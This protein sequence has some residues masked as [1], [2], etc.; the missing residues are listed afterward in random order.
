MDR[1][2]D[3]LVLIVLL[4]VIAHHIVLCLLIAA[5]QRLF[6]PRTFRIYLASTA[7]SAAIMVA[8][9]WAYA[10]GEDDLAFAAAAVVV[11]PFWLRE[12]YLGRDGR[13]EVTRHRVTLCDLGQRR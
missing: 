2:I 1:L 8:G 10:G 9:L 6:T 12:L 7:L 3:A 4:G 5:R 11:S 13:E